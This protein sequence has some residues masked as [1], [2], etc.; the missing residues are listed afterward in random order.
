MFSKCSR[1]KSPYSVGR[2]SGDVGR[3]SEKAQGMVIA[4]NRYVVRTGGRYGYV[5][6]EIQASIVKGPGKRNR[7]A[8]YGCDDIRAWCQILPQK[9]MR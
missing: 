6:T 8:M 3:A 4:N 7:I 5:A 1:F 2:G 9:G